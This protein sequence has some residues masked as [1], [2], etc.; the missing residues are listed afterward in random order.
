[1][2]EEGKIYPFLMPRRGKM[3]ER[4]KKNLISYVEYDE[5]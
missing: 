3:T 2:F 1:M 4:E 5:R